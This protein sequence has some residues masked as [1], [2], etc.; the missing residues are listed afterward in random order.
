MDELLDSGIKLAYQAGYSSIFANGYDT[1]ALKVNRNSVICPS[2]EVCIDWAIYQKNV[3]IL[4]ND[5]VAED[6]YA[7]GKFFGDNS[8]PLL[9]RLEDGVVYKYVQS[10]VM[11]HGDPLMRRFNEIIN[12]VVESGLYNYWIS[13]NS[14]VLKILSRKIAIFHPLDGYYSFKLYHMLPAFYILSMGFC[15]SAICFMIELL[16]SRVLSKRM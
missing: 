8:E 15:I 2:F 1:E 3:S 12:R 9:C 4:L 6:N 11:F 5:K 7:K 16:Y 13:L 14:N 10:M